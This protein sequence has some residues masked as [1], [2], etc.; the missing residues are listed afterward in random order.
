VSR[1]PPKPSADDFSAGAVQRAV[2]KE[3]LQHPLT[4]LPAAAA[5][6]SVMYM[7]LISFDPTSFGVA[8]GTALFGAAAWVVN[9]F[10]R[11][12]RFAAERVRRLRAQR[13]A[14]KEMAVAALRAEC[15]AA[16]FAH[17][18]SAAGELCEAYEKLR[19][20]LA[21]R[22]ESGQLN[23]VRFGVLA[24]DTYQEGIEL[25]RAALDTHRAL[26]GIDAEKLRQ[27]LN[28]WQAELRSLERRARGDSTTGA[29]AREALET[30]IAAHRRRLAVYE[31][32]L[33]AQQ[34]LLAQCEALE[35]AIETAYLEVLELGNDKGQP[36]HSEA[37]SRLERA[38]SAA[39]V[40]EER[41]R[42]AHDQSEADALYL[43]HGK[44]GARTRT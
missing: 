29:A 1:P 31:E 23:A 17:G 22:A 20:L 34:R 24:E 35:S 25:L 39:R 37:A 3:T 30:Q 5:L 10:F 43:Q 33:G 6:V 7:G 12:E 4:V 2:L 26:Q 42:G 19:Q 16:E 11:G 41:L 13:E 32:R 28:D 18:V 36:F 38:V 40:V 27:E 21:S 14:H 8:F 15:E 9:Y 44:Q